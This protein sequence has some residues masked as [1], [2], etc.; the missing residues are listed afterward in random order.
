M[1]ADEGAALAELVSKGIKIP[2]QPAVLVELQKKLQSDD[3][4]VRSLAR[5]IAQDPGI[6]AMLFRA[7]RSPVFARG[8]KMESLDQVLMVI[9]VKQTF[10][11]VQAM[12]L[13]AALSDGTRKAFEIFWERSRDVAQMAAIIARDR[14][15]I[16]NVFPDQAY[17]AGIFHECG[18]PVLMQRFPDY[19]GALRLDD[20]CCWPNLMEEDRRFDLDHCSVGYLVARHWGLP[21][22]VCAAV[23]YHHELPRDELGAV[24]TL[25]AILQLGIHFYHRVHH[26]PDPLWDT[27]G[28][29]VLTE[30]G[31]HPD[32]EEGY[33]EEMADLFHAAAG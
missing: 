31:I 15:S 14:V 21:D 33:F 6:A 1:S 28:S 29:A 17:M 11:L 18:V 23:R 32:D 30:L 19:C 12:A 8:K 2:P 20:A 25:V 26:V 3:Y 22:F 16:C 24:C 4:D 10:N 7:A 27:I 9:G 13:S 5:I